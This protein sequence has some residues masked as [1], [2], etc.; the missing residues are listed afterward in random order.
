MFGPP[1]LQMIRKTTTTDET[2]IGAIPG[3][4]IE[5]LQDGIGFKAN[6]LQI[7][8]LLLA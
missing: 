1:K 7:Q 2:F 8:D 3:T 4:W 6:I 5:Q